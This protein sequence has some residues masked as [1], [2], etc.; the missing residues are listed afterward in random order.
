MSLPSS[1]LCLP[2]LALTAKR[3]HK[4]NI[5][6]QKQNLCTL[7]STMSLD[8]KIR[9]LLYLQAAGSGCG[10]AASL[11]RTRPG[12]STAFKPAAGLWQAR[13][14]PLQPLEMALE[15]ETQRKKGSMNS[16]V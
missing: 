2:L 15:E 9:A 7:K 5:G 1:C 12:I 11:Y 6:T 16:T 14:L 13:L 10:L 3:T 8:T 4:Q